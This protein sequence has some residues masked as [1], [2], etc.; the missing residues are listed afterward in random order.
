M[1]WRFSIFSIDFHNNEGLMRD[2]LGKID[3]E[4]MKS[5]VRRFTFRELY[6]TI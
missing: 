3:S 6:T 1:V 4:S 2:F 5:E